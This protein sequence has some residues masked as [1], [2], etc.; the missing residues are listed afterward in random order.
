MI[1]SFLTCL[2]GTVIDPTLPAIWLFY[3]VLRMQIFI[4]FSEARS[5]GLSDTL[6][7][8]IDNIFLLSIDKKLAFS[9]WQIYQMKDWMFCD[10]V[11]LQL[12]CLKNDDFVD[13]FLD[14]YSFFVDYDSYFWML[15]FHHWSS[16]NILVMVTLHIDEKT[17]AHD[18]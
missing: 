10:S 8:Y 13:C 4:F 16:S 15:S 2:L 11:C 14:W 12:S 3:L 1:C 18:Y 5:N 6:N 9:F 7:R 17:V